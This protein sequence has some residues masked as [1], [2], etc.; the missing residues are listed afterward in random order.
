MLFDTIYFL[1]SLM[2]MADP[3]L[4]AVLDELASKRN[5]ILY[6]ANRQLEK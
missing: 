3:N 4:T 6:L 5:T 2:H 1:A